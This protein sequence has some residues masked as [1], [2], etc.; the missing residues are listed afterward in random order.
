MSDFDASLMQD[1]LTESTELIEQLDADLVKLESAEDSEQG[2]LLN[3]SF[4]ALHTIKGAASFLGLENVIRFAHV[5]EDALNRLRK[6]EIGM[7]TEVMDAL[8]QSADVV[9]IQ[10][11]QLSS[12]LEAQ[13]APEELV[14]QLHAI[15]KQQESG[16][17]AEDGAAEASAKPANTELD[18]QGLPGSPLLLPPQKQDLLE[19]MV[20]DMNEYAGQLDEII[21]QLANDATREDA[22]AQLAEIADNLS[23]T[24]DFFE[25][26]ALNRAIKLLIGVAETIGEAPHRSPRHTCRPP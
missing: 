21:E 16:D 18:E 25:L 13:Q 2:D 12:G 19:F 22:A 5:A 14:N 3:A 15:I 26:D 4:R 10:I 24:A 20:A 8:L 9:R 17:A 11:D 1:F 7:S 6:G 23:K